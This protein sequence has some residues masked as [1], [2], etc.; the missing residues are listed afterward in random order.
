MEQEE[1][2]QGC[3]TETPSVI[4]KDALFKAV[5]DN[6]P[7]FQNGDCM[8]RE[9]Y[10][11]FKKEL[12][13][14][15]KMVLLDNLR[16]VKKRTIG[17]HVQVSE[18]CFSCGTDVT[19]TMSRTGLLENHSYEF[20]DSFCWK[21]E[22][23]EKDPDF[24]HRRRNESNIIERQIRS[25]VKAIGPKGADAD[26]LCMCKD[27]YDKI[28]QYYLAEWERFYADPVTWI[29]THSPSDDS[30]QW[31]MVLKQYMYPEEYAQVPEGWKYCGAK[32]RG[33]DGNVKE[34]YEQGYCKYRDF[35]RNTIRLRRRSEVRDYV[36]DKAMS[37]NFADDA[38][39]T[40]EKAFRIAEDFLACLC[41]GSDLRQLLDYVA[42]ET[43]KLWKELDGEQPKAINR[44]KF[45]KYKGYPVH[46]VIDVDKDYIDWAMRSVDGFSLSDDEWLHY[47]GKEWKRERPEDNTDGEE[48]VLTIAGKK[49]TELSDDLV[50]H[51]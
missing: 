41:E 10:W 46:F 4:D 23:L 15:I 51:K 44:F 27:C 49:E 37:C 35:E 33:L 24:R 42:S 30:W 21:Y 43:G 20:H 14:K 39:E 32:I 2:G 19:K 13:R 34:Y 8:S 29:N 6:E 3:R 28:K 1:Q 47:N 45:G 48:Q 36:R 5:Q 12:P 31:E 50:G 7:F 22:L 17:G 40:R 11:Y 26:K 16:A 18:P 25:H 38:Q 9:A